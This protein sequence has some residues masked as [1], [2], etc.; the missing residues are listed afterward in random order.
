MNP[1]KYHECQG[2]IHQE[3]APKGLNLVVVF[4]SGTVP[5]SSHLTH[6]AIQLKLLKIKNSNRQNVIGVGKDAEKENPFVQYWWDC[7]LV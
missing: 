7:K 3:Q 2:H 1:R 4:E 6:V 5:Y